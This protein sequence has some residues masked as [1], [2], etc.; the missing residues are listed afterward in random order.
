MRDAAA[1]AIR[2]IE[3]T[4]N[5]P[6]AQPADDPQAKRIAVLV[7]ELGN[8][9]YKEREAAQNELIDIGWVALPILRKAQQHKDPEIAARA[10]RAVEEILTRIEARRIELRKAAKES[11]GREGLRGRPAA[12]PGPAG[13][14]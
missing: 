14:G 9:N 11:L 6:A 7:L 8:V 1:E 4:P 10:V 2:E 5:Q 12:I 3:K 13:A